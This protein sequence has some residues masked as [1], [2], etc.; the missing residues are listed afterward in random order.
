MYVL[1]KSTYADS[2][3]PTGKDCYVYS[4]YETA[5]K[6]AADIISTFYKKFTSFSDDDI[7]DAIGEAENSDRHEHYMLFKWFDD[8]TELEP[9]VSIEIYRTIN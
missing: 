1:I 8:L 6:F 7:R 3:I 9:T 2:G 4:D 5:V